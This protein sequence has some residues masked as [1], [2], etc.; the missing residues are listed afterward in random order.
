VPQHGFPEPAAVAGGLRD[1][2]LH[3]RQLLAS[4]ADGRL[5]RIAF[6]L[7][8]QPGLVADFLRRLREEH[9]EDRSAL[10]DRVRDLVE[11]GDLQAPELEAQIRE[12]L[13][14]DGDGP[15]AP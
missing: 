5:D 3:D 10:L 15:Q 11:Q 7:V 9:R 4:L 1:H 12:L 2:G 13:D 14:R 6:Q 8:D